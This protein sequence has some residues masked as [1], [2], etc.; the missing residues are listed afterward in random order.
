M[1]TCKVCYSSLE[2]GVKE[3]PECGTFASQ[4]SE[5]LSD[6]NLRV[7]LVEAEKKQEFWR[8][9]VVVAG[10]LLFVLG[11]GVG[12]WLE[13]TGEAL[14]PNSSAQA[15]LIAEA[16]AEG[17]TLSIE[18][19][20]DQFIRIINDEFQL[21]L[22]S[23]V[24]GDDGEIV[25]EMAVPGPRNEVALWEN[26]SAE[27][28]EGFM[29]LLGVLYTK[30]LLISGYPWDV[31]EQGHPPVRLIYRGTDQTLALRERSGELVINTSPFARAANQQSGGSGGE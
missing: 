8:N 1:T 10:F 16:Q 3:C 29:G 15:S 9:M 7:Q 12:K 5:D 17:T 19:I 28:Q 11:L 14:M 4:Y 2:A 27:E 13:N 30:M 24:W 20:N 6:E 18:E 31:A 22:A 25:L 26:L 21:G 23:W